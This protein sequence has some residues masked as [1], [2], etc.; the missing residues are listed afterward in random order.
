MRW[1]DKG[2]Q[3]DKFMDEWTLENEYYI[4][5]TSTVGESFYNKFNDIINIKGYVDNDV[6]KHGSYINDKRIYSIEDVLGDLDN[7]KLIIASG[8]YYEIADQVQKYGFIEGKDFCDSRI[9]EG[10][11]FSYKYN[12][13]HLY[14]TD[15]SITSKCNLKCKKC[16]MFMPYYNKPK[17]RAFE[18]I[19]DDIDTYFKWV[20]N[21]KLFNILGGEPFLHPNINEI[22]EYVG[23]NYYKK[24]IEHIEFFSNGTVKLSEKVLLN[25]KKYDISIQ[26]S[27][28][29]NSLEYLKKN[30][31]DFIQELS[32]YNIKYRRNIS[33]KWLDFGDPNI[34]N[35]SKS[36]DEMIAFFDKCYAP[37]RGLYNKKFYYC[38]LNTSAIQSGFYIENSNDYFN[39]SKYD[40]NRKREL[41]EFDLGY[42]ANGFLDYCRHCN[43]CFAVNE[44]YVEVAEQIDGK[45]V[46]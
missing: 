21:L 37:F 33:D 15:I 43:G 5:G 9:F 14:R 32:K 40:Q 3:F 27:D 16:N 13:V 7:H 18:E 1:V 10:V 31:D 17:H 44:K 22:I 38:H 24:K 35:N 25:C 46:N 2:K 41:V 30:V 39:L 28:Y 45:A 8:A 29:S 23:E 36:Q 26:V 4:W 42:N 12:K 20:D 34:R 19:K 11:Y 6:T